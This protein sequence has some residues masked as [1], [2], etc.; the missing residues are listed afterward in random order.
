ML[1]ALLSKAEDYRDELGQERD[2]MEGEIRTRTKEL[3]RIASEAQ[4]E[5][6]NSV[7]EATENALKDLQGQK[8]PVEE[9]LLAV[10]AHIKHFSD[11][12]STGSDP[13]VVSLVAHLASEAAE[14]EGDGHGASGAA[15]LAGLVIQRGSVS[16]EYRT[17]AVRFSD[18]L[19]YI[20]VAKD[21]PVH[22]T[23]AA[24]FEVQ[25]LQDS[26]LPKPKHCLAN[27]QFSQH[28]ADNVDEAPS[29]VEL[30]FST[31]GYA[32]YAGG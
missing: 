32:A 27:A 14:E 29:V 19:G 21:G 1:K 2:K 30:I 11:V 9:Q 26:I 24:S 20:G 5:A 31:A 17:R 7:F 16:V 3:K 12:T 18:V 10:E 28:K 23:R 4:K 22:Q 8:K 13:D 25:H 15:G 6:L